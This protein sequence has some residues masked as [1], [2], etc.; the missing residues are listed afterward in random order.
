[1]QTHSDKLAGIKDWTEMSRRETFYWVFDQYFKNVLYTYKIWVSQ[2][3]ECEGYGL[4]IFN[5]KPQYCLV[6]KLSGNI[7]VYNSN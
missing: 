3:G 1:M 6:Y 2:S 5:R 7:L 4:Y